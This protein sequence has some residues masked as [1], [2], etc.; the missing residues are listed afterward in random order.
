[1][2]T[3]SNAESAK[4]STKKSQAA[5]HKMKPQK[6]K[7]RKPAGRAPTSTAPEVVAK[8]EIEKQLREAERKIETAIRA[9][10]DAADALKRIR[11]LQLYKPKY[12]TF[13]EYLAAR[14]GYSASYV[15]R[16][17]DAEETRTKLLNNDDVQELLNDFSFPEKKVADIL[18]KAY[19]FYY[20]LSRY[21]EKEQVE[22]LK[23][24]LEEGGRLT[25]ARLNELLCKA[26]N[27]EDSDRQR[28]RTAISTMKKLADKFNADDFFKNKASDGSDAKK[29]FIEALRKILK[30][31]EK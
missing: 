18:P 28:L 8:P 16:L 22:S 6:A 1:M 4:K 17:V 29:E 9:F 27:Q 30:E 19:S 14:W 20:A 25:V 15:S 10:W 7:D 23:Q 12:E 21:E 5:N 31:L 26:T 13:P 2:V 3:K 24:L 11:E